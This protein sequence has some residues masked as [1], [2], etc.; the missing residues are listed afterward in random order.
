[1]RRHHE[2]VEQ[3]R[4]GKELKHLAAEFLLQV[5]L[6]ALWCWRSHGR[7]SF[8][9][10]REAHS[11]L[12]VPVSCCLV[13]NASCVYALPRIPILVMPSEIVKLVRL[14]YVEA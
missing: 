10:I 14:L 4:N 11:C 12:M 7:I 5:D 8:R 6:A 9:L 2:R 3:L 1:M 13:P